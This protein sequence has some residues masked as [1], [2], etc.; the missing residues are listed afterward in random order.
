[1]VDRLKAEIASLREQLRIANS[2]PADERPEN[3]TAVEQELQ[4]QLLDLQESYS[5]LSGRH[6]RLMA[7]LSRERGIETSEITIAD[8]DP[9]SPMNRIKRS[10]SFAEAVE[11]V[12]LGILSRKFWFN[13]EYEKTIQSLENTLAEVRASLSQTENALLEKE[14][15]LAYAE[16]I[17][18][19]LNAR[20]SKLT[21]REAETSEYVRKLETRLDEKDAQAADQSQVEAEIIAE[22]RIENARLRDNEQ[23]SEAYLAVLEEN[24]A[25]ADTDIEFW[26]R[27][28]DRLERVVERQRGLRKLDTLLDELDE[29]Q[30]E[31]LEK[32][33]N[34][35]TDSQDPA[36]PAE[37]AEEPVPPM[38]N[39][40][41]TDSESSSE[42]STP[43]VNGEVHHVKKQSQVLAEENF[44]RAELAN[45]RKSHETTV[46]RL[47]ELTKTY[48]SSL[49]CIAELKEQLEDTFTKHPINVDN[50]IS[51]PSAE[52]APTDTK[53]SPFLE[54]AGVRGLKTAATA[55]ALLAAG[56]QRSFSR[57][58][59]S[60]QSLAGV[61]EPVYGNGT[62]GIKTIETQ[63]DESEEEDTEAMKD[64]I[65]DLRQKVKGLEEL[66]REHAKLTENYNETLDLID[67]LKS[68]LQRPPPSPAPVSPVRPGLIRSRSISD[69]KNVQNDRATRA[70]D[71]LSQKI[72]EVVADDELKQSLTSSLSIVTT[73]IISKA[74]QCQQQASEITALRSEVD[75]KVKLISGLT[76]AQSRYIYSFLSLTLEPLILLISQHWRTRWQRR[77]LNTNL[78][79][80]T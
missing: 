13:E 28:V 46:L 65:L 68:Q 61:S 79:S 3:R 2:R 21:Q 1:M 59:S 76:K 62:A 54:Q 49:E 8:D 29:V 63:V 15:K 48:N 10:N 6:A 22:L 39:G 34:E 55:E 5:G 41:T 36:K 58:L 78:S 52:P 50:D 30:Q 12:I 35:I 77:S 57:S 47:E 45:L 20:V 60:E 33:K 19:Q 70:L 24:L 75:A 66:R 69:I 18:Q 51:P 25:E 11:M 64:E 72:S 74:S 40:T 7:E 73:E 37:K 26:K 27:E 67:E 42:P 53:G 16:S 80:T 44:I 43:K 17:N 31:A 71:T 4:D 23:S 38:V 32:A 14:S 56:P 9:N